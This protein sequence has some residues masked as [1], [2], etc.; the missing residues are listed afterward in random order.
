MGWDVSIVDSS[1]ERMQAST[2]H[3]IRGGTYDAS[4][5]ERTLWYSLTYNYAPILTETFG[6]SFAELDGK[7]VLATVPILARAYAKLE[8]DD[9]QDYWK[10]TPGNVRR[11]LFNMCVMA[12]HA[13]YEGSWSI[14]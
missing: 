2:P 8:D 11:A 14:T 3:G 13:Q 6:H 12:F 10:A 9:E 1:G 5:R 4:G 7:A